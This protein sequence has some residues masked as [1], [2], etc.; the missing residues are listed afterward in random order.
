MVIEGNIVHI[1][2]NKKFLRKYSVYA[3]ARVRAYLM[4]SGDLGEDNFIFQFNLY[5]PKFDS[6]NDKNHLKSLS[7][8]LV[9][10]LRV[11]LLF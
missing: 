3:R 7:S 10:L 5:W 2:A 8:V 6:K 11:I 4:I 1:E 9:E